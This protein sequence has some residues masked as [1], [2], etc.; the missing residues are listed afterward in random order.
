MRSAALQQS[1]YLL[2]II[3]GVF[4]SH[5]TALGET[6]TSVQTTVCVNGVC[7]TDGSSSSTGSNVTTNTGQLTTC[8]GDACVNIGSGNVTTCAGST[9]V[10]QNTNTTT[11]PT[12]GNTSTTT[13]GST[14]TTSTSSSGNTSTSG[15]TTTTSSS[16][17]ELCG[18]YDAIYSVTTT[19]LTMFVALPSQNPLNGQSTGIM[20][21]IKVLLRYD[22]QKNMFVLASNPQLVTIDFNSNCPVASISTDGKFINIPRLGITA[23]VNFFGKKIETSVVFYQA[24][25]KWQETETVPSFTVDSV[26]TLVSSCAYTLSPSVSSDIPAS[27][28]TGLSISLGATTS[29]CAWT[30]SSNVSWI[31]L[32]KLNGQGSTELTFSV[33]ANTSTSPRTGTLII[34]GQTISITQLG[35]EETACSYS[36][37]PTSI[38]I[39]ST[40]VAALPI[41][42]TASASH[43]SWSASSNETWISTS[44]LTGQG[45]AQV[46]LGV[47]M[48]MTSTA[49]TGTVNIAGEILSVRQTGIASQYCTNGNANINNVV[50]VCINGNCSPSGVK[51]QCN[52]SSCQW[53]N[54]SNSCGNI[55]YNGSTPITGGAINCTNG[56]CSYSVSS[57]YGSMSGS[58]TCRN[59]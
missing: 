24:T 43:C 6:S 45:S 11:S 18:Q 42:V 13:S 32:D 58:F 8:A 10:N 40:G 55:T 21:V 20:E 16:T 35:M 41:T 30:A 2:L 37:S 7:T 22:A 46:T 12:T 38:D 9:C 57:G 51:I 29:N 49:R 17:T 34:A 48:N 23:I 59:Q 52:S 15:S 36:I 56:Q 47:S 1:L 5:T 54:A 19:R 25:L 14:T 26:T 4:S 27:G 28:A 53:C 50:N 33:D 3:L 44:D 31:T 39:D